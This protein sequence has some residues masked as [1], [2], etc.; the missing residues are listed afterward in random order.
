[1]AKHKNVVGEK[2][3]RL[4]IL[5]EAQRTTNGR[6]RYF[7]KCLCDCGNITF[8]EK[9]KVKNGTTQSCGCLQ[10]ETRKNLGNKTKKENGEAAFNECYNSYKKSAKKRGY[11]FNLTK[12]EFAEIIVMPCVYC[13]ESLTQ[14]KKKRSAFGSFRYTGIDRY[15][16]T[17]GYV[18]GNCVPCC[19]V[20]N[21]LK[22]DMTIDEMESRLSRVLARRHV[23]KRTA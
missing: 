2:Y 1:M 6:K 18:S 21:R 16:N 11:E 4:K 7:V 23:W 3:G 19:K 17:K 20:C 15:D 9:S 5:E 14:E 22:S 13:G 8:V 12:T 10:T